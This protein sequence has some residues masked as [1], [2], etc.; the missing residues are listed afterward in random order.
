MQFLINK[1]AY[2]IFSALWYILVFLPGWVLHIIHTTVEFIALKLPIFILFG[3]Y[4]IDFNSI[5]LYRFLTIMCISIVFVIGI[6]MYR[7]F[8]AHKSSE[9]ILLFKDSF[10]RAVVAV[11][12]M[13]G[14]PI[15]IWLMMIFSIILFDFIKSVM[16]N[17]PHETISNFIFKVLEPSWENASSGHRAWVNVQN[18]FQ[19]LSFSDWKNMKGSSILLVI[20]LSLSLLAILWAIMQLFLRV[21]KIAA[22][23]F[24][25]LLWLPMSVAQGVNDNGETLKKWFAKFTE[26]ILSSFIILICLLLFLFLVDS[27]FIQVPKLLSEIIKLDGLE[28]IKN[29]VS[30][31]LSVSILIGMSFGIE[32][33]VT[34]L[35]Y[36]FNLV[37]F[38]SSPKLKFKKQNNNKQPKNSAL[39]GKSSQKSISKSK[40]TS[41]KGNQVITNKS[42]LKK[43]NVGTGS[44]TKDQNILSP[45]FLKIFEKLKGLKNDNATS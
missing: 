19:A 39:S 27:A 12:L 43:N 10:K 45:F 17:N 6:V 3:G 29:T 23:E 2:G 32:S 9:N 20:K 38:A 24:V 15:G 33:M 42:G 14:I 31:I 44:S 25:Y 5:F 7:L 40:N 26:C 30:S 28:S 37:E 22:F 41:K 18:N 21:V 35:M 16:I 8:Q 13:L 1:I 11:L 36:F 4:T 34:R